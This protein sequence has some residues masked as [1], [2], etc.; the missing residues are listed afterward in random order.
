MLAA[1]LTASPVRGSGGGGLPDAAAADG[2]ILA[3]SALS[4]HEDA[5]L[6]F[7]TIDS[8]P[9]AKYRVSMLSKWPLARL[10][11]FFQSKEGQAE[12]KEVF[13]QASVASG[14]DDGGSE[15]VCVGV[16]GFGK[17]VVATWAFVAAAE[18]SSEAGHKSLAEACKARDDLLY[19]CVVQLQTLAAAVAAGAVPAGDT[20]RWQRWPVLEACCEVL[21]DVLDAHLRQL[22]RGSDGTDAVALVKAVLEGLSAVDGRPVGDPVA[23]LL[24]AY[25]GGYF[26]ARFLTRLL[27]VLVREQRRVGASSAAALAPLSSVHALFGPAASSPHAVGADD[28]RDA[29]FET[30][31]SRIDASSGTLPTALVAL[32]EAWLRRPLR[33]EMD[34]IEARV[35]SSAGEHHGQERTTAA[36]AVAVAAIHDALQLCDACP[37]LPA[38]T[39]AEVRVVCSL[40]D[41]NRATRSS[42]AVPFRCAR[43]ASTPPCACRA[44]RSAGISQAAA[45]DAGAMAWRSCRRPAPSCSR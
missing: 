39:V 6:S 27:T 11:T 40:C 42:L 43:T 8:L 30:A 26:F 17:L 4:L 1:F 29:E 12:A 25:T 38:S 37:L 3:L 36:A 21:T 19:F 22:P 7:S 34:A 32:A 9:A 33:R 23:R 24:A 2:A 10:A 18:D 16:V 20:R 35:G 14:L 31:A 41:E 5:Q 44:L 28:D 15:K 13:Q 45:A